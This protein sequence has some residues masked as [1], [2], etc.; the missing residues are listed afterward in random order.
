M[1]QVGCTS[2]YDRTALWKETEELLMWQQPP[3]AVGRAK[4][5]DPSTRDESRALT[6]SARSARILKAVRNGQSVVSPKQWACGAAG[7]ALP[8]HGRGRRF[9]PDQVHHIP[10]QV[11]RDEWPQR[12]D[13][14]HE[15]CHNP[16]LWCSQRGLPSHCAWLPFARDYSVPTCG[17]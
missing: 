4:L 2:N 8:W 16:L 1:V 15:L 7:S 14:C 13:L 11:R 17:D 12:G 9:D 5:D 10:Q 3:S 6:I